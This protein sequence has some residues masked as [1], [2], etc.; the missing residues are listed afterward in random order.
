MW[1]AI[2]GT[3]IGLMLFVMFWLPPNIHIDITSPPSNTTY[4]VANSTDALHISVQTVPTVING[5]TTATSII[6]AFS[7]TL[8]GLVAREL[9]KDN[10]RDKRMREYLIGGILF[11]F[12]LI[13]LLFFGAYLNLLIGGLGFI[14][15]LEYAFVGL[16]LALLVL[17]GLFITIWLINEEHRSRA[18]EPAQN[19]VDSPPATT[20]PNNKKPD[21]P[22]KE[23][24][25][26]VNIFVNVS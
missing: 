22:N 12:P 13:L 2:V 11:L 18:R 26:N 3:F 1:V 7:G 6:F 10:E 25:K 16:L 19:R 17:V 15:A 14:I 21:E 9:L 20:E 4:T 5:I 24:E 23:H 8:V